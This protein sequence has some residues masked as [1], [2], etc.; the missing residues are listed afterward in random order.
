MK[1]CVVHHSDL[2]FVVETKDKLKTEEKKGMAKEFDLDAITAE[3][4]AEF[5]QDEVTETEDFEEEEVQEEV[6][7]PEDQVQEETFEESEEGEEEDLEDEVAEPVEDPDVHKRNEAFKKLREER[8]QMAKSDKFLE[9]LASQYG[10]TKEKLIEQ[11]TEELNK[12]QAKEQGIDP[13][14]FKKMQEMERKIQE[15]EESKAREVFNIRAGQLA[16]KY[17]L[18]DNQMIQLFQYAKSY[19]IDITGNPDL[20]D[21]VYRAVNYDNAIEVGRQNQLQTSKKRK[22]TSTGRTG[23]SGK[24]I[25]TSAE[26]M[27]K[28]IDAFLKEQGILKDK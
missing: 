8:D 16:Q 2:L 18:N 23:T 21:F 4:D 10:M 28:E 1:G 9:N 15:I 27:Q 12:K 7:E 20:L 13:E 25:D 14:Q 26:D 19:N 11:Y 5:A 17:N 3:L 6:A 24:Q 22:S